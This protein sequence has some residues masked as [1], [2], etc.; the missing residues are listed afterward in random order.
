[1]CLF[2][3]LKECEAIVSDCIALRCNRG[4][5]GNRW[6]ESEFRISELV[7]VR[8]RVKGREIEEKTKNE[9]FNLLLNIVFTGAQFRIINNL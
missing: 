6:N 8:E 1:M 4:N 7:R 9:H 5:R 3:K 2:Y